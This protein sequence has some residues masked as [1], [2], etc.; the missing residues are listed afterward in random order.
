MW[1]AQTAAQM[2]ATRADLSAACLVDSKAVMMADRWVLSWAVKTA[3]Q[4]AVLRAGMM[5]GPMVEQWAHQWVDRS[6]EL[7]AASRACW[8]VEST[9]CWRVGYSAVLLGS[10]AVLW[11]NYLAAHSE[12]L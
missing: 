11:G 12:A 6:D 7:L 5:A 8:W 1:V 3:A 9:A 2:V 10:S 4:T